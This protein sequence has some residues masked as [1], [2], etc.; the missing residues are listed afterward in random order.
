MLSAALLGF[1]SVA[2]LVPLAAKAAVCFLVGELWLLGGVSRLVTNT[3]SGR[4]FCVALLFRSAGGRY[5]SYVLVAQLC[6]SSCM[7]CVV[8]L[9]LLSLLVLCR[10]AS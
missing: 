6:A 2:V 9:F 8:L 10:Q 5:S 3:A 1:G 4:R 7:A